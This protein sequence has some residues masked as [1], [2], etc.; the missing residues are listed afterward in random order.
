MKY[1]TVLLLVVS[2]LL[3]VGCEKQPAQTEP[4]TEPTQSSYTI[5]S[6]LLGIW[7]SAD[8]GDREMIER[9]Y[10]YEDG[11]LI[12]ELDY[13]G[14]PYGSLYGTFSVEGHTI[15]CDIT[16]GTTPYQVSYDYRIDGRELIL[17]D[18]DGPATYLRT[19]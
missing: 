12:V 8:G 3:C 4:S 18:D 11:S 1:F 14:E 6:E 9:L 16:E 7:V 13:E 2:L 15:H 19:S 17:T 10:F 5:P